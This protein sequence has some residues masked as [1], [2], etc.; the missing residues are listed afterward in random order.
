MDMGIKEKIRKEIRDQIVLGKLNPGER[1]VEAQLS[2]RFGV[3]RGPIREALTQLEKEG[4]LTLIPNK[5]AAVAK[6]S[7]EDLKDFYSLL[8]LLESKAVEWATP[9]LTQADFDKLEAISN[10]LKNVMTCD[11]EDRLRFWAEH[12]LVFHR[13]FWDRCGNARLRWLVEE[14]RQRIFRYRYTSLM[15]TSFEAYLQDHSDIIAA[16]KSRDAARAGQTMENHILR[17]LRVLMEFFSHMP[18]L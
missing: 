14:I 5:G 2:K 12:N 17:A 15:V 11:E 1:L 13:F 10:S 4:F 16:V 7:A 6:I 18:N 3:S 9:S 8:A